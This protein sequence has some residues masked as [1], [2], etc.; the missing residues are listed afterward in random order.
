MIARVVLPVFTLLMTT[1]VFCQEKKLNREAFYAALASDKVELVMAQEAIVNASGM[2]QKQAFQGAL[3]M[4]KA[5]F[6]GKAGE[7][8]SI[9]KSGHKLL[10]EAIKKD[11]DNVE[12]RFLRLIIQENAPKVL[13]YK[14]AITADSE[15]IRLH[16][17]RL[18]PEVQK[19]VIDYSK[20]NKTLKPTD[21]NQAPS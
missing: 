21:F 9:F 12:F 4:K 19:A 1:V 11:N 5:G 2:Q 20:K 3:L 6:A 17:N 18:S 15:F 8:L 13:K 16:F 7:K 14:G 10:E